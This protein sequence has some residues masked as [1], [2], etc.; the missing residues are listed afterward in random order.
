MKQKLQTLT[1]G[2]PT[3]H[4]YSGAVF[5]IQSLLI[6]HRDLVDTGDLQ[7][8]VVDNTPDEKYRLRLKE[9]IKN[10]NN[11]NVR[12]IEHAEMKGPADA[13]NQ[14]FAN[15]K[16]DWTICIDSHVL[17]PAD[18]IPK[19]MKEI[20][21]L[22]QSDLYSGPMIMNNGDHS[23]HMDEQWRGHAW[24][25]WRQDQSVLNSRYP[26]KVW[27][28][29]CGLLLCH[30]KNW[31]GF[32]EDFNGFGGEEGYIHEKYRLNNREFFILPYLR[33]WHRFGNP[34]VK[35]YN[36]TL[37]SKVR[38]YVVS[39][40]ELG[41]PTLDGIYDH[42]V[43][44][45]IP[46][47]Q[48][49]DVLINEFSFP[50]DIKKLNE[51]QLRSLLSQKKMQ[52]K[53]W[54]WLMEDPINHV[55]PERDMVEEIFINLKN[56][57]N[58]DLRRHYDDMKK[59]ASLCDHVIEVTRRNFST[60]GLMAAKPKHLES[61]VYEAEMTN[62]QSIYPQIIQ[63][64]V[65]SFD[66]TIDSLYD[67]KRKADMYFLK[68]PHEYQDPL[69]IVKKVSEL[70]NTIMLH[71]TAY[72]YRPQISHSMQWLVSEAGF[73][74]HHHRNTQWGLTVLSRHSVDS[75]KVAWIPL[76]GPGTELKKILKSYGLEQ[77]RNCNC[78]VMVDNMNVW[79]PSG[80]RER[81]QDIISFLKKNTHKW[82]NTD[83]ATWWKKT[84]IGIGFLKRFIN[85]FDPYEGLIDMAIHNAEYNEVYPE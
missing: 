48:L 65:E 7:I 58:N 83:D 49:E 14:V 36:I 8:L 67:K 15:S 37:Y 39:N 73:K 74:V 55:E 75:E 76:E 78:N 38:N 68:F 41:V 50:E 53:A 6:N 51:N 69:S 47:E 24:G 2:F 17:F 45:D 11:D 34:D 5:T 28:Q 25:I 46:S 77:M 18:V 3:C 40:L 42:F 23:T 64:Q 32:S 29:G 56:N 22:F 31:L 60:V 27:G 26:V 13:K 44:Q 70:T 81:K 30:T 4:D 61:Y 1:V 66:A 59:Y 20:Q 57:E 82:L 72:K 80:C 54:K 35:H 19:V 9:Q 52:A 43:N 79:G 21:S 10:I 62:W 33:W 71:D 16:T 84:T 12:Y 63:S 85:P